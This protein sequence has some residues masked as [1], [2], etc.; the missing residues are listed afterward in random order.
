MSAKKLSTS[1]KQVA[2]GGRRTKVLCAVCQLPIVDGKD[3]A[4]LCEGVCNLWFHRGCASVPPD[5]YKTLSNSDEPFVC[6]SCS[7]SLFRREIAELSATV[8]ALKEELKDALKFRET[9][10]AL[11]GEV[12]TLRQALDTLEKE[13]KSSSS[14]RSR[15]SKQTYSAAVKTASTG[16]SSAPARSVAAPPSDAQRKRK[17]GEPKTKIKVDG[18]RRVWGTMRAC[19]PGTIAATISR[20][21]PDKLELRIKRKTKQL[22]NSK[23]VWWFVIHGA[24]SDLVLLEQRWENIQNQTS[25][26]LQHCLMSPPED[27]LQLPSPNASAVPANESPQSPGV[28]IPTPRVDLQ[29]AKSHDNPVLD[30]ASPIVIPDPD[31][32]PSPS[33][34][35]LVSQKCFL[36]LSP[37]QGTFPPN[38]ISPQLVNQN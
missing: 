18:A 30:S 20:L 5:L 14:S 9:C 28:T 37:S 6:L 2:Q 15:H 25:W 3:E 26:A 21:V 19:S 17:A 7:N 27:S 4:L 38:Q 35:N 34:N 31:K 1:K 13:V 24:E 29:P 36:S 33:P 22:A 16:S 8:D 23:S 32:S 11:A 12:T 10:S